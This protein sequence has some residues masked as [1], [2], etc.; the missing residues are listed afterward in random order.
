M[1]ILD[2]LSGGAVSKQTLLD[3]LATLPEGALPVP[4]DAAISLVDSLVQNDIDTDGDG[5]KDA[6]S[7][8]IKIHGIDATVSGVRP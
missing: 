3:G 2:G 6:A 5:A 8:G 7:I 4:K 1:A